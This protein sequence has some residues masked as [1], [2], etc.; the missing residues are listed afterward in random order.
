MKYVDII[1]PGNLL[2]A[3]MESTNRVKLNSFASVELV[4]VTAITKVFTA[5]SALGNGTELVSLK[6]SAT[7][8]AV[9]FGLA[10]YGMKMKR[11]S[12]FIGHQANRN[13]YIVYSWNM[14]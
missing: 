1:E 7:S 3:L 8:T 12:T 6:I 14:N 2:F 13:Q 9:P 4:S 10:L 11:N 5:S